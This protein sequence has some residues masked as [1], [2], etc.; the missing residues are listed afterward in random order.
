MRAKRGNL[1]E[2]I[3]A[4]SEQIQILALNIAVAAAKMS[5]NKKMDK[6][7]NSKLS[8]LVN[9]ATLAVK[10][11]GV[12]LRA[13]RSEKPKN[14]VMS[15]DS[16]APDKATVDGIEASLKSI[17]EDSQKIMDMLNEVRQKSL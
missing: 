5:F 7:V 10:N 11:M 13:A 3:E 17:L 8:G 6:D 15:T 1:V 12:I 14:N 9:E 2:Y 4:V 16:E